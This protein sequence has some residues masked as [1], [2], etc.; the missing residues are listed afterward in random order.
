LDA[1]VFIR[2]RSADSPEAATSIA[3]N[4]P[5]IAQFLPVLMGRT[6]AGCAAAKVVKFSPFRRWLRNAFA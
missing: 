5:S 2:I 6:Q 4:T 1:I 3:L